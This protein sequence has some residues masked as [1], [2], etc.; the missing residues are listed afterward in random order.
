MSTF[1]LILICNLP[2][3]NCLPTSD[4]EK[5][6]LLKSVL[7]DEI[8]KELA[9]LPQNYQPDQIEPADKRFFTMLLPVLSNLFKSLFG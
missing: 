1:V 2:N 7:A 6:D 5:I 4:D 9:K 3:V 8:N